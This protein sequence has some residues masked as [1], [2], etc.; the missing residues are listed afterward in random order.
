MSS[1]NFLINGVGSGQSICITEQF[2]NPQ[3]MDV[4][5][6]G[7][8]SCGGS[9]VY[10]PFVSRCEGLDVR[11]KLSSIDIIGEGMIEAVEYNVLGQELGR[12][13]GYSLIS[14]PTLS[15]ERRI[16]VVTNSGCSIS[17]YL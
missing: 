12:Y 16:I 13:S 7:R 15:I 4:I 17:L 1:F 11:R 6:N 3:W 8:I 10:E 14:I 5:P 9:M 2:F